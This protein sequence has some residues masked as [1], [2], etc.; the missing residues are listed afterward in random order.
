VIATARPLARA[1]TGWAGRVHPSL[2]GLS[3]A[4]QKEKTVDVGLGLA[5]GPCGSIYIGSR[6]YLVKQ[7]I[8]S[9]HFFSIL[10]YFDI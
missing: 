8:I 9:Y 3:W 1:V 6:V 2:Y 7:T 10:F 4:A 5:P